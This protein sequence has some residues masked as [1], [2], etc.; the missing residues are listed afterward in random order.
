MPIKDEI[1]ERENL[2]LCICILKI[3]RFYMCGIIWILS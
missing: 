2:K 1:T 3:E